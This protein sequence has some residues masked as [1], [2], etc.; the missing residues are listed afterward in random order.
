MSDNFNPAVV[1]KAA[2]EVLK[3]DPDL[4]DVRDVKICRSEFVNEEPRNCPWIGIYR[5]KIQHV[6][7][8][9]GLNSLINWEVFFDLILVIQSVNYHTGSGAEDD[10]E[11]LIQRIMKAF[12]RNDTI[13]D[14]VC[15]ITEFNTTPRLIPNQEESSEAYFQAVEMVITTEART[16]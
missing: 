3:S 16:G 12:L 6:P 15:I 7:R 10:L 14:T 13:N 11:D 9:L 4:Q 1:T 2:Q 5:G 8:T